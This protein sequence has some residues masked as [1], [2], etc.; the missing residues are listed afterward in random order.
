MIWGVLQENLIFWALETLFLD[1]VA[2]FC[3]IEVA[4]YQLSNFFMTAPIYAEILCFGILPP[5]VGWVCCWFSPLLRGVFLRLLSF[6]P[7]LKTAGPH[8]KIPILVWYVLIFYYYTWS[9]SNHKA[10]CPF[11]LVYF[12]IFWQIILLTRLTNLRC[13]TNIEYFRDITNIPQ[14]KMLVFVGN[15]LGTD[16]RIKNVFHVEMRVHFHI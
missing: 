16:I 1:I 13:I 7:A 14:Q 6:S 12:F 10:D 2:E 15:K 5:Y 8:F 3:I 11:K 9:E 4:R